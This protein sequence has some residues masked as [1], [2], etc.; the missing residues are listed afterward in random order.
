LHRLLLVL[1]SAE[2]APILS[3]TPA[4]ITAVARFLTVLLLPQL[5]K[6]FAKVAFVV[7]QADRGL[8]GQRQKGGRLPWPR[9]CR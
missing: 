7:D 5:F 3:A 9:K 6:G 4:V 2:V 8:G 1:L